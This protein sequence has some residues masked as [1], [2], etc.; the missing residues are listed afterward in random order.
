MDVVEREKDSLDVLGRRI[1]AF[2]IRDSFGQPFRGDRRR[3][4]SEDLEGESASS[5]CKQYENV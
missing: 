1:V 4:I 3:G 5:L 2:A